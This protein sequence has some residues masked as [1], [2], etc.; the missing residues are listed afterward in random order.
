MSC[1]HRV[2]EV[3]PGVQTESMHPVHISAP[4]EL[5]SLHIFDSSLHKL[6]TTAPSINPWTLITNKMDILKCM[7]LRNAFFMDADF[8][9]LPTVTFKPMIFLFTFV[10]E[11]VV[12][13]GSSQNC[14]EHL[15][16]LFLAMNGSKYCYGFSK[17]IDWKASLYSYYTQLTSKKS[18]WHL[19][20]GILDN[21]KLQQT[22][23]T[24]PVLM[25]LKFT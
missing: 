11:T 2:P 19:D 24:L 3:P 23:L 10:L 8:T 21:L 7:P 13:I 9:F 25:K 17:E 1:H 16:F 20:F 22:N 6:V 14:G 12:N 5:L 18:L 4:P 15:L